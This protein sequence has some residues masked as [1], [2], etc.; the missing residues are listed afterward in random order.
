[1]EE[2]T[3]LSRSFA[4]QGL[5]IRIRKELRQRRKLSKISDAEDKDKDNSNCALPSTLTLSNSDRS[6][7]SKRQRTDEHDMTSSSIVPHSQH[8]FHHRNDLPP[9]P[10]R[11]ISY[12]SKHH[13]WVPPGLQDHPQKPQ[14][15]RCYTPENYRNTMSQS[16]SSIVKP[17]TLVVAASATV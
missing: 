17:T 12:S 11:Y 16:S 5:K 14:S 15:A 2:S 8:H 7:G 4:D 13:S 9:N 1:M 3:F 10:T 6:N